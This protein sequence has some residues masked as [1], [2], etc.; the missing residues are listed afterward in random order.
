MSVSIDDE[1]ERVEVTICNRNL[2]PEK[3]IIKILKKFSIDEEQRQWN[4]DREIRFIEQDEKDAY[5]MNKKNKKA[6]KFHQL[7]FKKKNE[8][9][10]YSNENIEEIIDNM[11][12][13]LVELKIKVRK[14]KN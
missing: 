6:E 13:K 2:E 11:M 5:K 7:A 9:K 4:I 10:N 3:R 12:A 1:Y 8:P 14:N